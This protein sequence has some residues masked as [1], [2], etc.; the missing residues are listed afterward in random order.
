MLLLPRRCSSAYLSAMSRGT[1]GRLLPASEVRELPR[2]FSDVDSGVDVGSGSMLMAC[3]RDGSVLTEGRKRE[4]SVL[5]EPRVREFRPGCREGSR[6]PRVRLIKLPM[7]RRSAEARAWRPFVAVAPR[8][9]ARSTRDTYNEHMT[10]RAL[11]ASEA[12][13]V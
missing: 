2:R 10:R 4:G 13:R 12:K 1:I 8:C 11:R 6:L 9:F 5:T 7:W 3:G